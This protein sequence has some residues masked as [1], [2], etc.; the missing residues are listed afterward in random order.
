MRALA[1][2]VLVAC[3]PPPRAAVTT[4]PSDARLVDP[5]HAAFIVAERYRGHVVVL[6]FWASW[7]EEC[8][9]TVPQVAR[10]ATAFAQD[11][12]VVIGVNAGEQP[13]DATAAARALGIAYPVA[14]DPDF[15]FSERLGANDL[16]ALIVIDRDGQIVHR[17]RQVDQATLDIIRARLASR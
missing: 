3:T 15:A 5:D 2:A 11:G 13:A 16:P 9:R 14:L 12:L 4:L 10:L 1:L 8:K 7:C 17:A 6:D